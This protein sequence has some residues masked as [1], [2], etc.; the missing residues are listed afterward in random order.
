MHIGVKK[1]IKILS[2]PILSSWQT[3]HI[4]ISAVAQLRPIKLALGVGLGMA[5]ALAS[6]MMVMVLALAVRFWR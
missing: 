3:L 1:T 4:L 6:T 5:L 2:L